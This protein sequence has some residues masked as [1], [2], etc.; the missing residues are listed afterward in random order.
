MT[1]NNEV[2]MTG[3]ARFRLARIVVFCFA[4]A[5]MVFIL[6]AGML[7]EATLTANIFLGLFFIGWIPAALALERLARQRGEKSPRYSSRVWIA[8]VLVS[9]LVAAAAA[10]VVVPLMMY[11]L[12]P[13]VTI[14]VML[15]GFLPTSA[16]AVIR[17]SQSS[18]RRRRPSTSE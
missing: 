15:V 9:V 16:L 10:A 7:S 8:H 5:A 13:A 14:S 4:L 11:P 1:D 3:D 12:T 6:I 17:S 2:L 18:L